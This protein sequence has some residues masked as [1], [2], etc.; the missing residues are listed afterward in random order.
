MRGRLFLATLVASVSLPGL[1][2]AGGLDPFS[3]LSHLG[4]G[5]HLP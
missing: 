5:E 2:I 4:K 1:A 3:I